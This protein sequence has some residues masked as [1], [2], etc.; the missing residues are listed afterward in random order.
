MNKKVETEAICPFLKSTMHNV[1][2][3]NQD[4]NQQN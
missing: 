1:S 3:V 2:L 4:L